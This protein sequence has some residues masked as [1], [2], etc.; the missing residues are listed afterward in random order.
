[1][2]TKEH[3]IGHYYDYVLMVVL[4]T[5]KHVEQTFIIIHAVFLDKFNLSTGTGI[6]IH[7]PPDSR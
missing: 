4:T 6:H 7:F 3:H 2:P 1:M 5:Q